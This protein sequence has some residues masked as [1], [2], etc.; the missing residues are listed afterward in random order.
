MEPVLVEVVVVV[1]DPNDLVDQSVDRFSGSVGDAAV[2]EV[3]EQF[4]SPGIQGAGD[5]DEFGI[6]SSAMAVNQRSSR[7]SIR[8]RQGSR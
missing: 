8:P 3:G 4:R 7:R 1:P 2:V 5:A 6:S